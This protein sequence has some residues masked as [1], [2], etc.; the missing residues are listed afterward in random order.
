VN[1]KPGVCPP[2]GPLQV[3]IRQVRCYAALPS[4]VCRPLPRVTLPSSSDL[5]PSATVDR[6]GPLVSA[7]PGGAVKL[8]ATDP[9]M[10]DCAFLLCEKM[11]SEL[12][13]AAAR[14]DGICRR[15][16]AHL[17]GAGVAVPAA[18]PSDSRVGIEE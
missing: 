10:A 17:K 14:M 8:L 2:P 3:E 6:G 12:R 15:I 18:P 13:G 7:C 5:T 1:E 11:P 4:P 16:S 9:D